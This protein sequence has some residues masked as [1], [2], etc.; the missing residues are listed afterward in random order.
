MPPEPVA[1][2]QSSPDA[3]TK[4]GV[5]WFH[6]ETTSREMLVEARVTN[7]ELTVWWHSED[8]PITKL[9]GH[10]RGPIPP[11]FGQ[12]ARNPTEDCLMHFCPAR[13]KS[14]KA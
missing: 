5:Y 7:G 6:S 3:P 2:F 11:L 10:W 12:A 1:D 9:K 8:Q 4:P 14:D 13:T